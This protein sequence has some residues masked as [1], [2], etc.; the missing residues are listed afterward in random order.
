MALFSGTD[1]YLAGSVYFMRESEHLEARGR[2]GGQSDAIIARGKWI[3]KS[4]FN[5]VTFLFHACKYRLHEHMQH[6]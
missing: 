4:F 1:T 3:A 5:T 6:P 2:S